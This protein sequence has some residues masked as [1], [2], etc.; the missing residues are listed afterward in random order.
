MTSIF[1]TFQ[2]YIEYF[3]WGLLGLCGSFT[4][5]NTL[6]R[7]ENLKRRGKI[8]ELRARQFQNMKCWVYEFKDKAVGRGWGLQG[9]CSQGVLAK[10][11][12]FIALVEI[13][14]DCV[15]S[16]PNK[17]ASRY[18][19]LR[20]SLNFPSHLLCLKS[21]RPPACEQHMVLSRGAMSRTW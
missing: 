9:T 15:T 2:A 17:D 21:Q 10:T 3:D 18:H 8:Y 6:P 13:I 16:L 4:T 5:I 20:R 7:W 14:R 11:V 12:G 1:K 19:W